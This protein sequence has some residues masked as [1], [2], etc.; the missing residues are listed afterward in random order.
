[1]RAT[2]H[3]VLLLL[4]CVYLYTLSWWQQESTASLYRPLDALK[5]EVMASIRRNKAYQELRLSCMGPK[6]V[7]QLQ[8]PEVSYVQL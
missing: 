1:V 5:A 2:N 7:R 8:Q 4:L 3:A 6:Y